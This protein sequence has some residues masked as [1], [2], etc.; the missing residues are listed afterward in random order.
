MTA[1]ENRVRQPHRRRRLARDRR[2]PAIAEGGS[3]FGVNRALPCY[4][5]GIR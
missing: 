3:T 5:S 2:Y 1:S 4:T